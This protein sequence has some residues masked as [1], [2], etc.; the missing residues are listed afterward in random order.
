M[1]PK[2][3][4][5]VVYAWA[6]DGVV[7]EGAT[8]ASYTVAAGDIAKKIS[9][10][11]TGDEGS[12]AT[13]ET[14]AVKKADSTNIEI[15][16][17]VQTGAKTVDVKFN[18]PVT[19]A[20][21]VSV[22]KVST[23]VTVDSIEYTSDF[24]GATLTLADKITASEYTVTLTPADKEVS[25][26]SV[27][28]TGEISGLKEIAFL[29]NYLVMKDNNYAEGYAYVK[30]VD[31]FGGEVS[32]SG[33]SVTPGVGEF[34]SYDTSTGKITIVDQNYDGTSA[35]AFMLIKEV[36]V[37][38]QY[39]SGS[40]VMT[41]SATLTVSTRAYAENVEFGEIDKD[42]DKR[43]DGKLTV[44]ELASNKYYVPLTTVEDQYGNVLDADDLNAQVADNVLFLI[45]GATGA[46][47]TTGKFG[48]IK[49]TTVLWLASAADPKPGSMTLTMTG[50]SGKSFTKD[51]TIEDDPYIDVLTVTYPEL[52]EN[53]AESDPI[54]FSAVDQYGQAVDLWDFLPFTYEGSNKL[55]FTDL[56]H[57]TGVSTSITASGDA[58]FNIVAKDTV[59]KTFTATVNASK[60]KAKNVVVFT[61][62]T[63]GTKVDTKSITVGER[64]VAAKIKSAL[65]D[66]NTQ[67]DPDTKT[68]YNFNANLQFEDANG[69]AMLRGIDE[70]Y[71]YFLAKVA[72][73]NPLGS[74]VKASDLTK[75]GWTLTTNKVNDN[76]AATSINTTG[77]VTGADFDTKTDF[78]VTLFGTP[79][80]GANWYLLDSESFHMT[81]VVGAPKSYA[82]S[83]GDTM[84]TP[85]DEKDDNADGK[86]YNKATVKV[87]C[88]TE[89]NETYTVKASRISLVAG[90][91]FGTSANT[92]WHKNSERLNANFT[93]NASV[94]VYVDGD[95]IDSIEIPYS[96]VKPAPAATNYKFATSTVGS[97]L[98]NIS[99]VG[100][101]ISGNMYSDDFESGA[102]P[103]FVYKDGTLTIANATALGDTVTGSIVDQ[104]GMVLTDTK[105]YVNGEEVKDEQVL[106]AGQ[107]Y[108]IQYKNGNQSKKFTWTPSANVTVSA[109]SSGSSVSYSVGSATELRKALAQAKEDSLT[110]VITMTSGFAATEDFEVPAGDILLTNGNTLD[111]RSLNVTVNGGIITTDIDELKDTKAS[112]TINKG[113]YIQIAYTNAG[114]A[115]GL[116]GTITNKGTIYVNNNTQ[117]WTLVGL[118][119]S[120]TITTAKYMKQNA[121]T[122]AWEETDHTVST[123]T[124]AGDAKATLV[125]ISGTFTNNSGSIIGDG[126]DTWTLSNTTAATNGTQ[127]TAF[128]A[129][130]TGTYDAFAKTYT[131]VTLGTDASPTEGITIP[132]DV[133]LADGGNKLL[134]PASTVFTNNGV[135]TNT[136]TTATEFAGTGN[137]F[138]SGDGA[139]WNIEN[140]NDTAKW[141]DGVLSGTVSGKL[142]YKVN[143]NTPSAN[144]GT[145]TIGEN[146]EIEIAA[147]KNLTTSG[148]FINNGV[149]KINGHGTTPGSLVLKGT[150][151]T[152]NGTISCLTGTVIGKI[153]ATSTLTTFTNEGYIEGSGDID[154]TNVTTSNLG[155][156]IV[157]GEFKPAG[158]VNITGS[159]SAT[160]IVNAG[161]AAT[162][163]V[164]GNTE[165][166]GDTATNTAA[167]AGGNNT[168][169]I[170]AGTHTWGAV[171]GLKELSIA[172]GQVSVA[173]NGTAKAFTVNTKTEVSGGTL[174]IGGVVSNVTTAITMKGGKLDLSG[175]TLA[176]GNNAITFNGSAEIVVPTAVGASD[177]NIVITTTQRT[178]TITYSG[179][180]LTP[181]TTN[182]ASNNTC[183]FSSTKSTGTTWAAPA[184]TNV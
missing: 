60:L 40:D 135:F 151:F 16:S 35:G 157:S 164:S 127:M 92:I 48:T 111:L 47:Y 42:G 65:V 52:Y 80:N 83:C 167:V 41:A 137:S 57:M 182:H 8:T 108:T 169:K 14:E 174:V 178:D 107:R 73:A 110:N 112:I 75:F 114:A 10:T 138:V 99:K 36:P 118:E 74:T 22:K 90:G 136:Y 141:F 62:T 177:D 183:T 37:F 79:D 159:L 69:N 152:N 171:S 121:T 145:I 4:T 181:G 87:V 54:E 38:V 155:G 51:I 49:N 71:P 34:K 19:T 153:T 55:Y 116:K 123:S 130:L 1:A 94:T 100:A 113:G 168:I 117:A 77:V 124:A 59:K 28:F 115:A 119:N 23:D 150:A 45:P 32:L 64:G 21:K 109:N 44:T 7:I 63:A 149:I 102:K 3:A 86:A 134:V 5:N 176:T 56:N 20:D 39:Q 15:I 161:A 162:L 147:Q 97:T 120:G 72:M 88:T 133:E 6:A 140:A 128:L 68:S 180:N 158:T 179:G 24:M 126:K 129:S 84:Y 50:A 98:D 18:A 106:N 160:K 31:Q 30:G 58:T 132:T 61:A 170:T 175:A 96:T 82:V 46:F 66:T 12:K 163:N 27:S 93:D 53:A 13:A 2:D 146:T 148:T 143:E 122:K 103:S 70:D 11:V 105:V 67:L 184:W 142:T 43:A 81:E 165:V 26:S 131:K 89:N 85:G 33:L 172:D 166:T 95:D 78:Y 144:T 17:A 101:A 125:T 154:L 104:Y 173:D 25:A 9:V 139:V 29:N 156:T 76:T 91:N